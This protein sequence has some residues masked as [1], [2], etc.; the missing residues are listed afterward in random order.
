M[1][2]TSLLDTAGCK[3][4]EW[5]LVYHHREPYY[6]FTKLL[7][8]GF[9]HVELTRPL[10]YG[11]S[12]DD[13]AWLN[14]LPM[15]E[16]LDVDIN[17]ES[18]PPWVRC[19]N[20]TVQKV[21]AIAPLMSVRSWFDMGP[22]TCVEVVK[23]ALGIRAFWVRSPWQLFQYIQ[24]RN[25][26]IISGRRRWWFRPNCAAATVGSTASYNEREPQS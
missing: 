7:K 26:V 25:G 13:V 14:V 22:P 23:M 15:F 18:T 11:P 20:S 21:T 24:K 19:P 9:R 17:Y 2:S 10:Q 4:R 1:T 6:S 5:Y 16:M 12:I 3:V 8:P